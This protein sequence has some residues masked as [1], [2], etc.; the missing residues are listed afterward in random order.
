MSKGI[1]T[2]LITIGLTAERKLAIVG[3]LHDKA[4]CVLILADAL[5]L[6]AVHEHKEPS[7]IVV[8]ECG[9]VTVPGGA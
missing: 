2:P 7:K 1:M 3:P 4:E 8:P 9:K 5:K 6:V